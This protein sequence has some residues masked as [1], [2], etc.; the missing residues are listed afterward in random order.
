MRSVI[1]D[2]R[3]AEFSTNVLPDANKLLYRRQPFWS[4]LRALGCESARKLMVVPFS[5]ARVALVKVLLV[6][7]GAGSAQALSMELFRR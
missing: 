4:S 6:H 2:G 5:L 1:G 7:S 3:A